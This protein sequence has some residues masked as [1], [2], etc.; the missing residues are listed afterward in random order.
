M[1]E[2]DEQL[3][4]WADQAE[5]VTADEARTR[6][7]EPVVP[8]SIDG[9]PR[10]VFG[11]PGRRLLVAA[12]VA[13]LVI[14]GVVV[15]SQVDE[16]DTVRVGEQPDQP[17]PDPTD[18]PPTV[19]APT[20]SEPGPTESVPDPE[21]EVDPPDTGDL[22]LD[23][24]IPPATV[25]GPP[26]FWLGHDERQ[27]LV[28]VDTATGRVLHVVGQFADDASSPPT[29][30]ESIVVDGFL[31]SFTL[32][33]DR[34]TVFAEI[35]CEPV[36]G[37]I[38]RL[39]MEG[40]PG[41]TPDLM[42]SRVSSGYKMEFSPDGNRVAIIGYEDVEVVDLSTGESW[43]YPHDQLGVTGTH[44]LTWMADSQT[45]VAAR[46][47]G[48][49]YGLEEYEILLI[50]VGRTGS[51]DEAKVIHR[52]DV[53]ALIGDLSVDSD[54]H[55]QLATRMTGGETR[56]EGDYWVG[57]SRVTTLDPESS[58]VVDEVEY[59]G[60]VTSQHHGS[61]G[62]WTLVLDENGLDGTGTSSA[63]IVLHDGEFVS[64][65]AGYHGATW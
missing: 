32:A 48:Q 43:A 29:G 10:G 59:D 26:P 58:T 42:E 44:V 52:T 41:S 14:S 37:M 50:E 2:L 9:R 7:A 55:V 20:A 4:A 56:D 38:V 62:T 63:V 16:S 54:G 19:P 6:A 5:S 12:A 1:P 61:D 13:L 30:P 39:P 51:L 27:R 34:R 45:L 57:P 35:C 15:A 31:G 3:R 23:G 24:P 18:P 36:S 28:A 47:V 64:A 11:S 65:H 49:E 40:D 8:F 17:A 33:P 46:E 60:T 21:D 22:K 53:S 25:E